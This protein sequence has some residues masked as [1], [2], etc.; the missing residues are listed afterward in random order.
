[1]LLEID[2]AGQLDVSD[3]LR[4]LDLGR[5]NEDASRQAIA[6]CLLQSASRVS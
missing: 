3:H 6:Q 1:M 2:E 5:D 4:I